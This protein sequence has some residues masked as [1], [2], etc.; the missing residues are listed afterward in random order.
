MTASDVMTTE[1]AVKILT[2]F[3]DSITDQYNQML[4]HKAIAALSKPEG[5]AV[6]QFYLGLGSNRDI[7]KEEYD[8]LKANDHDVRILFTRPAE[9]EL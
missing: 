7:T 4:A 2:K 6:Y 9:G 8:E 5:E 1:N 3:A